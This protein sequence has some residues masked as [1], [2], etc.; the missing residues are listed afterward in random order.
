[1]PR[2]DDPQTETKPT[3]SPDQMPQALLQ[4]LSPVVMEIYAAGDFHRADMRTVARESGTSFRTIYKYFRDKEQLLFWFINHWLSE[5]YPH[6]FQPL[7]EPG[8][9]RP[10]LLEVLRRHFQ[11]YERFPQVGR[12]IFMT[13]PLAQWMKEPS[14]AQPEVM[15]LLL[16]AV[17]AAQASGELRSD[18]PTIAIL[19]AVNALFNRTFL[20][21]E[22]RGR[23]Y[24]LVEQAETVC[25]ILW[26]GIGQNAAPP[27]AKS[28][29]ARR[30]ASTKQKA[31]A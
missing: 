25:E 7:N 2:K 9:M 20:M 15:A 30:G 31:V 17:R 19:D 16:N 10:K 14:Y 27:T 29:P 26:G 1:M 23:S 28:Q 3:V 8:P 24:S 11:F 18:L 6:A 13:V 5:L 21:W 12:I 4:K 22:Y